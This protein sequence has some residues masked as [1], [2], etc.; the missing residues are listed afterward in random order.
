MHITIAK[1]KKGSIVRKSWTKARLEAIWASFTLCTSM[2]DINAL[3]RSTTSFSFVV[4]NKLL[5]LGLLPL[6][7]SSFSWQVSL[8]SGISNLL[9]S[10]RQ[11]RL[12]LHSFTH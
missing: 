2:S 12:C 8:G 3:F 9:G 6:P 1:W 11:A 7:V 10:P 4:C 5:S